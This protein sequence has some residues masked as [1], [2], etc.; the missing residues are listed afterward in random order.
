MKCQ[1]ER[2]D[3]DGDLSCHT[4]VLPSY[5][6][7]CGGVIHHLKKGID[8]GRYCSISCKVSSEDAPIVYLNDEDVYWGR[9]RYGHLYQ[10]IVTTPI[11]RNYE[12][13][14]WYWEDTPITTGAYLQLTV[15]EQNTILGV[16]KLCEN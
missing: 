6:D 15:N 7:R 16:I 9:T 14:Y 4:I 11:H 8:G 3:A 1:E 13:E 10:R 12:Q 5:C 2:F